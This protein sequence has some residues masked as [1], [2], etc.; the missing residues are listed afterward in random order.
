[1][2]EKIKFQDLLARC[3][4]YL[5]NTI[6]Q[7]ELVEATKSLFV[8]YYIPMK[9]KV[10]IIQSI[11]YDTYFTMEPIEYKIEGIEKAKILKGF[12][13][14]FVNIEY[15]ESDKELLDKCDD[16]TF[17]IVEQ[18]LN[19]G[20]PD[21]TALFEKDYNKLTR[22]LDSIV[23]QGD[24]NNLITIFENL[25]TEALKEENKKLRRSFKD[26]T[27]S[28]EGQQAVADLLEIARFNDPAMKKII[29]N[30]ALSNSI[31]KK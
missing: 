9:E 20:S 8:R 2:K 17:E 21:L 23:S 15:E 27:K 29:E 13:A 14:Y 16:Y 18:V 22:M 26:I 5:N 6:T 28:K 30:E 11:L 19:I 7:E 25:D 1:M 4:E 24:I 12:L 3:E 31:D 10:E